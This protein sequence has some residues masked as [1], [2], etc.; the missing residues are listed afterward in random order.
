MNLLALLLA[1]AVAAEAADAGA[2]EPADLPPTISMGMGTQKVFSISK[3]THLAIADPTVVEV[4]TLGSGQ[5][6][7]VG[8]AEGQSGL[9]IF[10]EGKAAPT[11]YMVRVR[12]HYGDG[13][14][15][16]SQIL[17]KPTGI[18]VRVIGDR[19]FV[20]GV[21]DSFETLERLEIL[22]ELY[23]QV[24]N[25]ASLDPKLVKV[26]IGM[27]NDAL[28]RAGFKDVKAIPMGGGY[29]L[30]GTVTEE[31][32]KKKARAIAEGLFEPLRRG[33]EV[34]EKARPRADGRQGR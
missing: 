4:K 15:E 14:S 30:E 10:R 31:S 29:A 3:V 24:M 6:L 7:L 13:F 16:I 1:A 5:I 12:K 20:D 25:L 32:D 18:T 2:P 11:S 23:P 8:L 28:L 17:G 22:F 27:I 21:I 19:I 33:A 26:S 9:M 34:L